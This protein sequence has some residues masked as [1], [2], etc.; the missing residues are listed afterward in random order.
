MYRLGRI[1]SDHCRCG[2]KERAEHLLLS[3]RE[4]GLKEARAKAQ[5][6]LRTRLSLQTM[7]HT[8]SGIEATLGFL[9]ETGIATRK[10]HL[11]RRLEEEE[12]EEE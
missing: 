5:E 3:C 11:G 9:K 6:K 8:T 7:L 2:K 1:N 4:P 10:W 12:E